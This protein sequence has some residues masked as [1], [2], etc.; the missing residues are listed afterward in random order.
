MARATRGT[1]ARARRK[2]IMKMASG[3]RHGHGDQLK[4]ARDSVIRGFKYA[5]RDRKVR[6]RDM[7]G[8]WIQRINAAARENGLSY[9]RLIHGLKEAGVELDRKAL[10]QIAYENP[11]QFTSIVEVAKQVA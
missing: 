1:K 4:T 2:K 6:K 11:A 5:Y 9:S 7:R 8:L 3:R 10:A